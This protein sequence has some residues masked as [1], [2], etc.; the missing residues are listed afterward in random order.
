ME[1]FPPDRYE[2]ITPRL[3]IRHAVPKDAMAFIGLLGEVENLPMGETEA[4][5][6]LT[7]DNMT[8]RI[9][10]WRKNASDGKNAVLAIAL[11]QTDHVIG[12][13]GFNC[14]RSKPEADKTEPDRDMPLSGVEGRYLTDVGVVISHKERRKG[15]S[16]EVVCAAIEFA[17]YTLGCI[18]VRFETGIENAP[19]QTLMSSFGFDNLKCKEVLSYGDNP[20]GWKWEVNSTEWSEARQ[21]LVNAG[22]WPL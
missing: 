12:Y 21:K 5:K 22:S 7:V 20:T 15:Y 14:F 10:K 2:I 18:V 16:T 1:P 13:M 8:E 11:C 17:L 19:W 3:I 6:G 4:I 9:A